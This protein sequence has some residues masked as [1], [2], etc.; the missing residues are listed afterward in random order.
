MMNMWNFQTRIYELR[1]FN[2]NVQPTEL[3]KNKSYLI[4][5]REKKS[6][7]VPNYV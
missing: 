2:G 1:Y 4:N 7:S 3:N 6:L 5:C